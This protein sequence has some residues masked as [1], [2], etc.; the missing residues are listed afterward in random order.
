MFVWYKRAGYFSGAARALADFTLADTAD[1]NAYNKL[2]ELH[3]TARRWNA[4]MRLDPANVLTEEVFSQVLS[5]ILPVRA[6]DAAGW[7]GDHFKA[8]SDEAKRMNALQTR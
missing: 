2:K 7:R 8:L 4:E 1:R 3:P 6:V 5:S